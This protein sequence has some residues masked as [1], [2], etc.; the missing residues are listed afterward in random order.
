M[1]GCKLGRVQPCS[2][3]HFDLIHLSYVTITFGDYGVEFL[4]NLYIANVVSFEIFALFRGT[5]L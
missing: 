5:C 3:V 2:N 1:S 4:S